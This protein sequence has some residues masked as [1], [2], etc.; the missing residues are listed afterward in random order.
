M[1]LN[2]AK[3]PGTTYNI[4]NVSIL[5]TP[6][7]QLNPVLVCDPSKNLGPHQYVNDSCFAAPTVPG[8]NPGAVLPAVYGPAF[9]NWDLGLFK[10]FQIKESMKIQFRVDGYNF[11]NHPL[12]SFP[13]GN[14]L[15][16]SIDPTT[17]RA[18]PTCTSIGEANCSSFGEATQKQGHRIIQLSVHFYF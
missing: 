2:G 9:F 17:L 1:N 16:L 14:N 6:D 13:N 15:G 12:W 8:S 10:N 18:Y 4:S 5:G 3:I 11:L 7:M